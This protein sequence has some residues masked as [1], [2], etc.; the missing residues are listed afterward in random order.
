M[1]ARRLGVLAVAGALAVSVAPTPARAI[2]ALQLYIEGATYD[3]TTQSWLFV[4]DTGKLWV[5]GNVGQFGPISNVWLTAAFPS[6]LTGEIVLAETT[7]TSGMLP[8]P[9]DPSVSPV[10]QRVAEPSS[11]LSPS[12]G[13]P[14]GNH[15]TNGTIPCLGDGSKLPNHG[16]YG[17]GIQWLEFAL[18]SF[19]RTDSPIGDFI[20]SFP[21]TFPTTGQIN[22]Y[23]F[24][25]RG[26]P[27]G[28]LIHFDAFDGIQ[29]GNKGTI[30]SVFAPFS[31]DALDQ[32]EGRVPGPATL[33]VVSFG[34]VGLAV[35]RGRGRRP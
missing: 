28:T 22:A 13:D 32:P 14:C 21:T 1:W 18:G 19:T 26:F 30:R 16:E 24:T 17:P 29:S 5:L 23:A 20:D 31:H 4:G 9:G 8:P 15:G 33:L 11:A 6:G 2:P 34:L 27:A 12:R 25:I 35:S 3:P 7:A 10:P